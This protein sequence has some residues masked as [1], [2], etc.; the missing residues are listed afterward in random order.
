MIHVVLEGKEL[1]YVCDSRIESIG[2]ATLLPR[3]KI[4]WPWCKEPK[5]ETTTLTK[6]PDPAPEGDK[7]AAEEAV[8]KP[9]ES[10]EDKKRK[11]YLR[12][13][14]KKAGK[15]YKRGTTLE[16]LEAEYLANKPADDLIETPKEEEEEATN[17]NIF[18]EELPSEDDSNLFGVE[19]PVKAPVKE[20]SKED[21]RAII[22]GVLKDSSNDITN[23]KAKAVLL[24]KFGKNKLDELEPEKRALYLEA[25]GVKA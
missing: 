17:D 19:E 14:L 9:V 6:A 25:L 1:V 2:L 10:E 18:D 7:V 16:T 20:I 22:M 15:T 11:R 23:V 21:M 8:E 3:V 5:Q 12:D 4:I 13:T 24:D